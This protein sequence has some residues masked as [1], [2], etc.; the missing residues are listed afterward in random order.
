MITSGILLQNAWA[1]PKR[2]HHRERRRCAC[3]QADSGVQMN[4][5]VYIFFR[6]HRLPRK[7]ITI[8]A[9]VSLHTKSLLIVQ[10]SRELLSSLT[11]I[12]QRRLCQSRLS[13][14]ISNPSRSWPQHNGQ[15]RKVMRCPRKTLHEQPGTGRLKVVFLNL[16][17]TTICRSAGCPRFD[18][19]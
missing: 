7:C 16:F 13:T 14:N 12:S 2:Y 9:D 4:D 8:G 19:E 10:S 18:L 15:I 1:I 3:L 17:T 6:M 11:R 5:E